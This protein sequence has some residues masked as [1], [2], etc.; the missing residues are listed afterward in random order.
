MSFR[1]ISEESLANASIKESR[2]KLE[3]LP[4]ICIGV[5]MTVIMKKLLINLIELYQKYLSFDRGLL[6]IFAPSGA[7]KYPVSCS[8]YTR[9]ALQRFGVSKGLSLG[10]KRLWRCR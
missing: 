9:L 5:R 8:E 6:F 4:P 7:C 3:I 10:L 2:I 1:V